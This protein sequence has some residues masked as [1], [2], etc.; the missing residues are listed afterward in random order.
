MTDLTKIK[1]EELEGEIKRRREESQ[2]LHAIYIEGIKFDLN[3]EKV[4][5][6]QEKLNKINPPQDAFNTW[7]KIQ[8]EEIERRRDKIWVQPPINIPNW[9][10]YPQGPNDYP[11]PPKIWCSINKSPT[12]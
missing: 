4:K 3:L 9:P 1:T 8:E 11:M 6:L 5:E 10:G 12:S 2:K 7:R